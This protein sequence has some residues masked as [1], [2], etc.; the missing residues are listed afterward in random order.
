MFVFSVSP[1]SFHAGLLFSLSSLENKRHTSYVCW[2]NKDKKLLG[3]EKREEVQGGVEGRHL[4]AFD[5]FLHVH[6]SQHERW[7]GFGLR[8]RGGTK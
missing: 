2:L 5:T 1:K 4:E 8:D 3:D 7:R 6:E